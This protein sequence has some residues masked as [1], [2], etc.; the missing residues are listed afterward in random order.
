MPYMREKEIKMRSIGKRNITMLKAIIQQEIKR[1][2]K[3]WCGMDYKLLTK[4]IEDRIPKEWYDI[5]EMSYS[6][7][8]NIINDELCNYSHRR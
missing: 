3:P 2:D 8:E 1:M 6:Q 7:I 5:W 4:N